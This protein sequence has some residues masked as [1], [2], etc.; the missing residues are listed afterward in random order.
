MPEISPML[1]EQYR[2]YMACRLVLERDPG[3]QRKERVEEP[4]AWSQNSQGQIPALSL[5]KASKLGP[6]WSP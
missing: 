4:Q 1:F 6:V 3:I 2:G 5:P